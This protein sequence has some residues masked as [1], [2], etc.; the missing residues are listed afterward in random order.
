M[1]K[2]SFAVANATQKKKVGNIFLDAVKM[3]SRH[4]I[5]RREKK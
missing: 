5:C 2:L 4:C 1:H 3:H